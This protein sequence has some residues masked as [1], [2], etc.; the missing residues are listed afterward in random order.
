MK[1]RVVITGL[2][3]VCPIGND[4]EEVWKSV[5]EGRCGIGPITHYD[6]A[7]Q[8]VKLAGEVRDLALDDYL[9]KRESRKMD[10]Y[11]QF[12]MVAARQAMTDSGLQELDESRDRWGVIM[13]SGIGGISTIEKEKVR[14]MEKGYD[15]VSPHFIPM[16]IANMAAGQ[17]AIAYGL[18][19]MCTSIVTACASAAN[20]I[21]DSFR[22][23]CDGYGDVM[24]AGGSEAAIT[25]LCIGGFTSLK[26]MT[27]ATDPNRASIPFDA[28]RS[29]FVM[30][31]GA[32]ALILEE[33]E[34]ARK[35]GAHIYAEIVGYGA[36]CDAYHITAPSPDGTGAEQCMRLSMEDAEITPADVDYI[37]AHGTSTKMNDSCETAAIRRIFGEDTKR[38]RVSS[39]KSM[40]GH[41][42]GAS[43]A[44]EAVITAEA[45]QN[46]FLPPT[47]NYQVP[48]P[49]CDLDVV[50]G[51]GYSHQI[52]YALSNSF[53]FGGHNATLVFKKA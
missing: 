8:K 16:S 13:S 3:I 32:G 36:N 49:E 14:G 48:D 39:T 53:G 40:T 10:R 20:A 45:V 28:E 37:N 33:Y 18:H 43:A 30:G 41:L 9:D 47:V 22:H 17:I 12:A 38:I 23:I 44:V 26:A 5:T 34:H 46:D 29:G 51:K 15:R 27:S 1:R 35:R 31:E 42:L 24:V 21:G 25:P 11:T 7:D 2:G 4:K 52:R 6:P 50:P 19:G